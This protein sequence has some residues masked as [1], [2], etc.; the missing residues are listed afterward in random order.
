MTA[1]PRPVRSARRARQLRVL[2]LGVSMLFAL[3]CTELLLHLA[4]GLLP[5]SFRQR[6]P[7]NGVEF[8]RPG[9]L[10]QIAC[11]E[12]PLP[13]GVEPFDGPPPH[14]IIDFGSAAP[15]D[16]EIDR[17]TVPRL[18]VPADRDGLPNRADHASADLVLVGDS[19]TV[20]A[21]QQQPPGL[22]VGLEHELGVRCRN[23]AVSGIGPDHELFLLRQRGLPALPKLV[24][25]FFFAGND[26]PD[27]FW[28][29]YHHGLGIKTLGELF[30]NNRAP[31]LILPS[32]IASWFTAGPPRTA[33]PLPPFEL[34]AAPA[35]KLWFHPNT[36]RLMGMPPAML[37][38]NPGWSGV[39]E[40]LQKAKDEVAAAG[41][42]LLLV[43]LPS[44]EEVYLPYVRPAAERLHAAASTSTLVG[45]PMAET[46]PQF[47]ADLLQH[48]HAQ[49]AALQALAATLGVP[50]WSATGPLDAAAQRG[51]LVYYA[52]DTHW[53]AEAQQAVLPGLLD[54]IR[55]TGALPR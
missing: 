51:E 25:W 4:P 28:V 53:R 52:T 7:P 15:A 26:V 34:A 13:Y 21:A 47:L 16:A 44:K 41:A 24:V 49:E 50:F 5:A 22:Q 42:Q 11:D 18:V 9:L 39:T 23:L 46:P 36:L 54:A 35:T 3:G 19:F 27:A 48:R 14:D 29:R 38:Q 8:F 40:V 33:T 31:R 12:L 32:L 20:F 37:L 1:S 17:S 10:D 55:A 6:F 2:A 45:L 43:Y 30:A